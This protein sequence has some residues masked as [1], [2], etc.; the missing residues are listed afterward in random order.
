MH[1]YRVLSEML[2]YAERWGIAMNVAKQ[3][4]PPRPRRPELRIPTAEETRTILQ[5]VSGSSIEGPVTVAVGCGLRLGEVLALRWTDV[6]IDRARLRVTGTMYRGARSEP[7]TSRGRRTVAIPGFVVRWLKEHRAAQAER[8]LASVS[9]IDGGYVFDRG[10][11]V[12]MSVESVS[13]RFGQLVEGVGLGDVRYHDLRHAWAT[14]CLEAGLHPKI[15]SEALGHASVG[16]TLDTYSH[17]S[18]TLSQTAADAIEA[19]FG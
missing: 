7:K 5:A 14:R 11:G 16:I 12:P 9:W 17:V 19:V 1:T 3:V 10:A 8:Q 13:R 6:D 4:R 15:V 2:A 18:A